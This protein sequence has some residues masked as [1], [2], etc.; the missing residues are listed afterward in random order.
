MQ[1]VRYLEDGQPRLGQLVGDQIAPF[2]GM[3]EVQQLI[4]HWPN[5]PQTAASGGRVALE[6]ARLLA[7]IVP[8]RNIFCVGWNYLKHYDEGV[9]KREGQE[10]DLPSRPT[11]FTK[12]PTTVAGPYDPL[13]LHEDYTSKLDWEVE[14]AV[15]IGRQG[16]DISR[17]DALDYV[18]GYTVSNDI[19]ARDLQRA[20]GGQ[21]FKGK[22]LDLTCPLGPMIVT[23]D[24]LT[25]PQDLAVSCS[26]NEEMMQSSHT[27]RQIFD[28]RTVIAELSAGLTLMPGDLILTG[29]PEG[30][31]NART[32]PV[33]LRHGDILTTTIE[34]LG[35]MHN[36]IQSKEGT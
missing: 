15:I 28:V 34:R 25:D 10:V 5:L 30:I 12:L 26:V 4:A 1:I 24:E 9:G 7:P 2:P 19:S 36:L 21:W 18:F 35:S 32:P 29:T 16:R 17:E 8:V 23:A 13:P 6:S 11:F 20:H 33:F 3:A 27:S 22:S 31:G 14:L